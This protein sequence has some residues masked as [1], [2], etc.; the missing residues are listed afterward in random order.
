MAV[1]GAVRGADG[2]IAHPREAL[3]QFA[4]LQQLQAQV[5]GLGPTGI[6]LQGVE[7]GLAARQ[8]QMAAAGVLAVDADPLAQL[9]PDGMGTHRQWQLGQRAALATDPAI[10]H[11]AGVRAT[12]VTFK[13]RH[14]FATAGQ[15]QCSAAADDATADDNG[16]HLDPLH[17]LISRPKGRGLTGAW[18]RRR[19][20]WSMGRPLSQA[21]SSAAAAPH[22]RP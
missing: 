9:P 7:V 2:D 10:V 19:P 18:P 5:K 20:T 6:S 21:I 14:L 13:Q 16:V 17:G 12:E 15:G 11:P 3:A 4:V 1:L 22:T 8:L